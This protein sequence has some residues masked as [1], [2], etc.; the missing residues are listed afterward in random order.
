[1]FTTS[2]SGSGKD[3]GSDSGDEEEQIW[4][5]LKRLK[6][7][8][9]KK[10]KLKKKGLLVE[11]EEVS[12]PEIFVLQ[13]KLLELKEDHGKGDLH[14]SVKLQLV[15]LIRELNK[16]DETDGKGIASKLSEIIRSVLGAAEKQK[17][18]FRALCRNGFVS[19][20]KKFNKYDCHNKFS[21]DAI[22]LLGETLKE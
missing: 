14:K 19:L 6:L 16:V 7:E 13:Q 10:E 20:L 11:T 22:N 3:S 5:K 9:Q 1:M 15:S 4:E 2:G 17:N 12:D 18:S 21:G 8:E